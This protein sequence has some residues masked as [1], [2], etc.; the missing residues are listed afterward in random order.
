VQTGELARQLPS[1][2]RAYAQRRD[3]MLEALETHFSDCA[4]WTKPAGGMFLLMRLSGDI[5][6]R[7]LAQDA[8]HHKVA[9][10]PGAE[11]HLHGEGRN[12]LRL[13]FSNTPPERIEEG[14]RRLRTV[15]LQ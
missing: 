11:F 2:R 4:Q 6:G 10:V 13:N 7:Q 5:D 3:A 9:V 12:T 14:I 1:L 8:L 15:A